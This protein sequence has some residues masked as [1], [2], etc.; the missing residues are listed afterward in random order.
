MGKS[1]FKIAADLVV[2]DCIANGHKYPT[3]SDYY[4]AYKKFFE[5]SINTFD[6]N[7]FN[8]YIIKRI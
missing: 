2:E 8:D 1:D 6:V 7:K 4:W 3:A 5:A